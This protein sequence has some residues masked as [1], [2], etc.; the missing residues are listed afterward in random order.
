MAWFTLSRAGS[1]GRLDPSGHVQTF[2]LPDA[3]AMPFGIAVGPDGALW[4]TE[5]TT[6]RIARMTLDGA[7]SEIELGM[8]GAMPS[9]IAAGRDALWFTLNQANALGRLGT[10]GELTTH[11]L[12]TPDPKG[13]IWPDPADQDLSE[14]AP[15][16]LYNSTVELVPLDQ[17]Q[18][19]YD[20]LTAAG[21]V[22]RLT[23]LEGDLHA[24]DYWGQ[25]RDAALDW[26]ATYL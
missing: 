4:V 7:V 12:P 3:S 8:P 5:M 11:A 25:V 19:L 21:R 15:I 26:L 1:I 6:Q 9:M 14:A 18:Y 17:A 23:V 24:F 13:A 22:T 10:G 16:D 20:R 2:A